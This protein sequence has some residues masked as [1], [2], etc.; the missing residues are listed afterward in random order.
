MKCL[1]CDIDIIGSEHSNCPNCSAILNATK[2]NFISYIGS[3]DSLAGYQKSYKLLLLKYVIEDS[4]TE[5]EALVSSVIAK[6][7]A[8]YLRR[9]KQ[10]LQPD[11]DVDKRISNIESSSDY[12]VFAVIKSQPYKVINEKGYLFINRNKNEKLIFV[13]NEDITNAMSEN[14]WRILLKIIDDKLNL[15]YSQYDTIDDDKYKITD[16][17]PSEKDK[18]PVESTT[19]NPD[20]PILEV[21]NLSARAKKILMRNKL[22]TVGATLEFIKNNDLLTLKNMGKKTCDE[23]LCLISENVDNAV[24]EVRTISPILKIDSSN[25]ELEISYLQY[26]GIS[27]KNKAFFSEKGYSK[28]GQLSDLTLG[29]LIQMFGHNKGIEVL[30]KLKIFETPLMKIATERLKQHKGNREFNIYIERANKKTLQEIADKYDLTRERVRQIEARFFKEFKP[31][32]ESLVK[33]HML[34]N[35][36]SYILTQDVLEF[37]D[38]D[39]FDTVIMHTLKESDCLEYLPFADMFTKKD[40]N[41]RI[42][43]KLYQ[44]TVGL[45]GEDGIN[46]F[47]S[48]PQIE[49]MLNDSNLDFISTDAY[50]NYLLKM[51]VYFYGNY[52]YLKKQPYAKLCLMLI[53]KYFKNGINLHSDEDI[54]LLRDYFLKEFGEYNLPAQNRAISARLSEYLILCDRG[55]ANTIENIHY[56]QSVM[57]DIKSYIDS[58]ELK[59]LYFSEIFNEFEGILTFTSDITNYHG[60]HGVLS[61]LYRDEYEF[62]RDCITKKNDTAISL[63]L[64][65]RIILFINQK[66]GPA[67]RAE[68]KQKIGGLSDIML[69]NAIN[70]SKVLLQW[71]YNSFNTTDNLSLSSLDIT[72]LWNMIE[73]IFDMHKGYCSDRLIFE[74]VCREVPE[75]IAINHIE[76][77]TN[78][79]YILQ[80]LF[81]DKCQFSRPHICQKGIVETPNTKNIAFYLLGTNQHISHRAFVQMARRVCWSETTADLIFYELEKDYVR[82][83]E[84]VYVLADEFNIETNKL[85]EIKNCLNQKISKN[86]YL[87]M[88]GFSDFELFPK[89]EYE[90][91]SFLLISIIN[92]YDVGFKV[93]SPVI[94]DRRYNKEIIVDGSTEYKDLSDVVL[95]LLVQAEINVIDEASLLSFLV[96][97]HLVSKVIPKELYDSKKLNYSD[98][99]FSVK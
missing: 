11:Y 61:Y 40:G 23:I 62:S 84:D 49:E 64:S 76:N 68:I 57:D 81:S 72:R 20:I 26:A 96:V 63:S 65:E 79:F 91:N 32:F 44:L 42:E 30:E 82:V 77:S 24:Q 43:E 53:N 22:Y 18:V 37:F 16:E 86:F 8:F 69:L 75:F 29:V 14:E 80:N 36:L 87:S 59:T 13:F 50:L 55:K 6:I 73:K 85:A 15:Y 10:G 17:L 66:G 9:K 89:I 1:N 51:N 21:S 98:G 35:N 97:H 94:K 2:N 41:I 45:L 54:N 58:S 3:S 48:L 46:F 38:D 60:L 88:I 93:I 78:L 4:L 67:S 39:E 70:N 34:E 71:D 83:S 92:R 47:E 28:I 27:A 5:N 56:E 99:Y 90:W 31:L 33:Q 12:D 74:V 52:I 25:S 95:A 7:K 19:I